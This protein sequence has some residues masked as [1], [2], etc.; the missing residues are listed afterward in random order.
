MSEQGTQFLNG[1]V[2]TRIIK[3]QDKLQVFYTN[4]NVEDSQEFDTVLF[5]TGRSPE[6]GFLGLDRIGV[7]VD[8]NSGF[9]IILFQSLFFVLVCLKK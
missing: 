5:A 1:F 3:N 8:E 6:S 4:G 9:I 2:P 7:N